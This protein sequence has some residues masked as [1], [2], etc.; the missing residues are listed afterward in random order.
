M[1][2][3]DPERAIVIVG[4]DFAG[5]RAK[6]D[7]ETDAALRGRLA[8]LGEPLRSRTIALMRR[9]LSLAAENEGEAYAK[10][11]RDE[12]LEIA[13]RLNMLRLPVWR[14]RYQQAHALLD[15]LPQ[16]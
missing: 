13:S 6:R 8:E 7:A 2:E 16:S 1:S 10:A 4:A 14:L 12:G 9:W 3:A 11:M 5:Q 15:S